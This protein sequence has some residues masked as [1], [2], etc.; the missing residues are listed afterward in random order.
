MRFP[1]VASLWTPAMRT[2]F[3]PKRIEP[4]QGLVPSLPSGQG[5]EVE[6]DIAREW[7][8]GPPTL[9]LSGITVT[10]SC[11]FLSFHLGHS[12]SLALDPGP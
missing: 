6:Q 7:T 2:T 1:P 4:L 8:E 12:L 3:S 5:Q 9:Q 11:S 10:R